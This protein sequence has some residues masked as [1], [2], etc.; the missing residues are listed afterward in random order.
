[1]EREFSRSDEVP[2]RSLCTCVRNEVGLVPLACEDNN[3]VNFEQLAPGGVYEAE[4]VDYVRLAGLSHF[5]S[6]M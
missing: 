1:M 2:L 4:F 5:C 6:S 3:I